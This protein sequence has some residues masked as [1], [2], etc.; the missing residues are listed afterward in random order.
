MTYRQG[1]NW[2]TRD[3]MKNT[4][5]LEFIIQRIKNLEKKTHPSNKPTHRNIWAGC[6]D[7][8]CCEQDRVD[9]RTIP[10]ENMKRALDEGLIKGEEVKIG[11]YTTTVY[12]VTE[13]GEE[14][15]RQ[16]QFAREVK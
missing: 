15:M 2:N 9:A 5:E 1:R 12:S 16:C 6:Y 13:I 10:L 14:F 8:W 7:V 4:D 3:N 11:S